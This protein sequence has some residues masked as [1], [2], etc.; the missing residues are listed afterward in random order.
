MEGVVISLKPLTRT[1]SQKRPPKMHAALLHNNSRGLVASRVINTLGL[2]PRST[3]SRRSRAAVVSR[4][5]DW[6]IVISDL[7]LEI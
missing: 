7:G 4:E 1:C 2:G 6:L 5:M 3:A